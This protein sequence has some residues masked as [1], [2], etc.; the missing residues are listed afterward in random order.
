M[1]VNQVW[2]IHTAKDELVGTT[3]TK[4]R[5]WY[6]WERRRLRAIHRGKLVFQRKHQEEIQVKEAG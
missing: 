1:S 4:F 6:K 2:Y 3:T 5:I